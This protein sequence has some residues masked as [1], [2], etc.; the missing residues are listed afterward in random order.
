MISLS[1]YPQALLHALLVPLDIP[2]QAAPSP[3]LLCEGWSSAEC[4]PPR[5]A[6]EACGLK[7][8]QSSGP[9]TWVRRCQ[10]WPTSGF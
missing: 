10:P 2:L 5:P 6:P 1:W 3:G 7:G 8:V 4:P 9:Q